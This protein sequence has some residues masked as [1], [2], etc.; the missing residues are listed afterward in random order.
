MQC[1][2][3]GTEIIVKSKWNPTRFLISSGPLL[4]RGLREF[5]FNSCIFVLVTIPAIMVVS[6]LSVAVAQCTMY[7]GSLFKRTVT[8]RK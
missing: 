5:F 7:N 4:R 2:V 1:L 8:L 3:C 6:R